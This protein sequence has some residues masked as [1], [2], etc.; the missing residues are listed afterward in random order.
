MQSRAA[1]IVVG[2]VIAGCVLFFK[3]SERDSRADEVHDE[4][5]GY[6]VALPDYQ[7]HG[8]LYMQWLD[9]HHSDLFNQHYHLGSRYLPPHFDGGLYIGDLFQA[10]IHDASQAGYKDQ[11]ENLRILSKNVDW[12]DE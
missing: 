3:F 6:F 11:A 9:A 7:T 5:A 8:S 1:A 12:V 10:M 2:L 4:I